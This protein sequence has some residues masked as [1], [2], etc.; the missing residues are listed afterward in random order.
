MKGGSCSDM[1]TMLNRCR[2]ELVWIETIFNRRRWGRRFL[3]AG[4]RRRDT[5]LN[6]SFPESKRELIYSPARPPT[7]G[8]ARRLAAPAPPNWVAH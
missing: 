8:N 4:V 1:K 6:P 3:T 5:L 2:I 7:V